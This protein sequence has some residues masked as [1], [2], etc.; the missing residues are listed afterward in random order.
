MAWGS[1]MRRAA[2]PR[3]RAGRRARARADQPCRPRRGA[4]EGH[5]DRLDD[6]AAARG[7]PERA[8]R[9]CRASSPRRDPPPVARGA[10]GRALPELVEELERIAQPFR[11]ESPSDAELRIAQAA[12]V[13][14]LEGLF[15]GI[16]TALVAQQMA[17]QQRLR[18]AD[19]GPARPWRVVRLP[20]RSRPR[21]PDN[22]TPPVATGR[23]TGQYSV[24]E[25]VSARSQPSGIRQKGHGGRMPL[26]SVPGVTRGLTGG[27]LSSGPCIGWTR[28]D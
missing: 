28:C 24:T 9:P 18:K 14:W 11:E 26:S 8:T 6:Q 20:A 17:A 1:R 10:Q 27:G 25:R 4:G 23:P 16:Q 2:G 19:A 21:P 12:L 7:G 22:P 15:H 13:G 3:G 5:A